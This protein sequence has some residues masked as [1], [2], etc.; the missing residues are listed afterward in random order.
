MR[1]LSRPIPIILVGSEGGSTWRF[2]QT[3]HAALS[4]AGHKVHVGADERVGAR[5]Q[6]RRDGC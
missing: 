1:R 5:V 3:L 2:A 6:A 4:K